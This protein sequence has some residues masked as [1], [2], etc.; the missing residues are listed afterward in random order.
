MATFDLG[1]FSDFAEIKT[2]FNRHNT[3]CSMKN[4]YPT[5]AKHDHGHFY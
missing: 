1:F 4:I 3:A 5:T 2:V